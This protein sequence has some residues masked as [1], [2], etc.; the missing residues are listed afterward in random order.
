MNAVQWEVDR[1]HTDIQFKAKHLMITTV[2]GHFRK[3]VLEVETNDEDFTKASKIIFTADINSIDTNNVQRDAHLRSEDFFNAK[4]FPELRFIGNRFEKPGDHYELHGDFTIRDTTK[5]IILMV[6]FS[7]II[8]DHNGQPRAG[9]TVD[10]KLSR[11]EFGLRWNTITEAGQFVVSDEIKM[12]CEIE[13]V[14]QKGEEH[15]EE[16]QEEHAVA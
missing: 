10:G 11:K 1:A 8:I 7:G 14:K 9:F 4:K 6:E 2:I 3:Y 12:H 13:L 15:V 16:K 5:S